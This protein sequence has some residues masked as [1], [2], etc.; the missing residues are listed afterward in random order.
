MTSKPA[1]RNPIPIY[2]IGS[3]MTPPEP[4]QRL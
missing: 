1:T 2:M 3:T 4:L